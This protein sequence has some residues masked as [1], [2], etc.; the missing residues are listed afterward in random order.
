MAD[1]AS[2]R[3]STHVPA[4]WVDLLESVAAASHSGPQWA[5]ESDDLDVTFLT[6][7]EGRRIEPHINGEVDVVLIG[8]EGS[9]VVAVDGEERAMRPGVVLLIPRGCE[10]AIQ[11]T[12]PRLGYLSV[13]KR[14]RGL[15]PTIGGVAI[16]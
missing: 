11:S 16:T 5:T 4:V 12:S 14:R 13:H 8:I 6:W 9:G 1:E 15:M 7:E 3:M 10:R 2:V